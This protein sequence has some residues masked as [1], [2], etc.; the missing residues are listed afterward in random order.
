MVRDAGGNLIYKYSK[1]L[2]TDQNGH[3]A[4]SSLEWDAY[5][6]TVSSATGY[7]IMESCPPQPANLL[8]GD[9]MAA[10][11][12][13]T[14]HTQNT[15][16]VLVKEG[17]GGVVEGA[18]AHLLNQALGYD[19]TIS[20]SS[21]GQ[22]FFKSLSSDNNYSLEV[23]KEGYQNYLLENISISGQNNLTVTLNN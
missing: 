23:V 18:G 11:L 14:A 17:S 10:T 1:N 12:T 6:I 20:S 15:F 3:L 13:L 16:L 2:T 7:D 9:S 4:I 5:Q 19:K 22:V 8:P 21:C